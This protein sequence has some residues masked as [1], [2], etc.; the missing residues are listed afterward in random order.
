MNG[1]YEKML[2]VFKT[3]NSC[4]YMYYDVKKT[5]ADA[6]ELMQKVNSVLNSHSRKRVVLYS[7]KSF[8]S[9]CCIFAIMLSGNTWCPL[10]VTQPENRTLDILKDL[11]ADVFITDSKLTGRISEY[12]VDHGIVIE[13]IADIQENQPAPF[14]LG[15]IMADDIAYIMFTSG[16]TGTPKGVPMT[17]ANYIPFINNALKILPIEKNEIFSDYHEFSFDLSVFYLFCAVMTESAFSPALNLKDKMFPLNHAIENKVT[18]WSSVPS[19]IAR[20]KQL[21]PNDK[22]DTHIKIMFLC[23]EPFR[24]D[25]LDYCYKNLNLKNIYNFYGL[26]ETGVENFYHKCEPTDIIRFE[27]QGFVPIGKPLPGNEVMLGD[28]NELFVAGV[29][30][31]PGY[32]GGRDKHRFI[33]VDGKDWFRSGDIV[34]QYEDL[35]FCKGRVDSQVKISGYRI[36][37]LDVEAG[38]RKINNV[39]EAVC[40][41]DSSDSIE[42]II[43]GVV[44]ADTDVLDL[45]MLKRALRKHLPDYMIPQKV[46]SLPQFPQNKSGKI[47]RVGIKSKFMG[48]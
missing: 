28:D 46:F 15:N 5:Y 37:L 16:S 19:S 17:H 13:D 24:L 21:R 26:T 47:D 44:V 8:E 7:E 33:S 35:F 29:Q 32:L 3:S 4:F 41:V 1:F 6:F 39:S 38:L 30:I 36:E 31:T 14:A 12:L 34:E 25:I 11:D 18:V 48:R 20:V 22:H 23:G 2:D 40:F 27:T 10:S 45:Q 42:K 9:Y 43:V